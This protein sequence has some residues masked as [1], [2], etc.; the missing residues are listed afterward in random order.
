MNIPK[1][2]FML[3]SYINTQLR[4]SYPSMEDLCRA[5]SL[6][7]E[8]IDKTLAAVDYSYDSKLNRYV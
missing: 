2:P 1:D 3:L 7:K 6:S 4:D 5:L 8:E